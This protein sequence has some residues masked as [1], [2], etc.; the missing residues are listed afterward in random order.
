MSITILSIIIIIFGALTFFYFD[1]K[2]SITQPA[3]DNKELIEFTIGEGQSTRDIA[4]GLL[5]AGLIKNSLYFEIYVRLNNLASTFQAGHYTIP[6]N[7]T[8][9]ELSEILQIAYEQDVW[10]TIP[11]GMMVT[12][13]ADIIDAE[14]SKVAEPLFIKDEFLTLAETTQPV[15]DAGL[16]IPEGK[17]C[18]GYL[19]P[20]TYR[21]SPDSTAQVVLNTLLSNF[22]SKIYDTYS[23]EINDSGYTLYEVLT[24]A[25]ILEKETYHSNDRY[26]VADILE[27]RLQ[28]G[29]ALEVDAT[30]LYHF[31]DW[32]HNITT[33]ELQTDTPYNTRKYNG[34]TPT[35]INNPG[36]ETIS[37]TLHP[38]ENSYWFYVSDKDG[39]LYYG[40]TLDEHNQNIKQYM[41]Q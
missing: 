30:L 22:K 6:Q 15:I 18:E 31:G 41:N 21:F 33:E 32:E 5:K 25:S 12:E 17:P 35:P 8:M 37:A 2:E 11:E 10:V 29:W 26:K 3:S 28:N 27:R 20:D 39:N 36:E 24:I 40:E 16:P 19:F 23:G 7:V 1:F 34:L 13:I 14:F 38:E 4:A 9:K